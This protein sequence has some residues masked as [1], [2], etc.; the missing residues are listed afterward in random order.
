MKRGGVRVLFIDNI[1]GI[2]YEQFSM[3]AFCG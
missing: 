2:L 1:D 3:K